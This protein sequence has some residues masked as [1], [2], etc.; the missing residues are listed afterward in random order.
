MSDREQERGA[1]LE[2]RAAGE[3]AGREGAA[4][5][6]EGGAAE[7]AQPDPS[8]KSAPADRAV[9]GP[10]DLAEANTVRPYIDLGGVKILPR[11]GLQLRLEVEEGSQRVVAVTLDYEGS[12]L[13]VQAF[14][15]PKLSG[16]WH[17]TR[18][19]I[20]EQLRRQGAAV[21]EADGP[22]G[23]E[24]SVRFPAAGAGQQSRTVRFVGVDGPRWLLRG[25]I[26]GPGA[27]D[28]AAAAGIEELFRSLV[29]V[30]GSA[31]MPPRELIP[32][33]LPPSMTAPAATVDI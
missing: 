14:A 17:E 31:P 18:A 19:Q 11:E 5:E 1:E 32:L 9:A 33:H 16:L 15:A 21:T 7:Q 28:P 25:A 13:Q 29:V 8:A 6:P 24:L 10:Y 27:S 26:A 12:T 23:P 20:A 2:Q 30:R 22:F 3:D 4:S